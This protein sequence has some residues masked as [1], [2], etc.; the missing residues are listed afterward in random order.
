MAAEHV[1]SN[2]IYADE[3]REH[4]DDGIPATEAD[5]E[6]PQ[7]V[8][9]ES[10]GLADAAAVSCAAE[11]ASKAEADSRSIYVGNVDYLC[12]TEEL[13]QHFEACGSTNRV[14]IPRDRFNSPLVPH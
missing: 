12:T 6:L 10:G 9:A 8:N 4:Y 14:T 7:A 1:R 2:S 13:Q 11:A 5:D 3:L